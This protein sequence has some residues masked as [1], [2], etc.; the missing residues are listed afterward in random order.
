MNDVDE[1]KFE[2]ARDE[3]ESFYK[4]IGEVWCP[5]LQEKVIFNAKGI[6]H[7][8]FKAIRQARSHRDQYIRFRLI[9]LAPKIIQSSH[10]L[11]GISMRKGFEREK[12]HNRWEI[13]MRTATYFEFVAVVRDVRVRIIVKQVENGP[14]YFWSIIPFWK[15]DKITGKRLLHNGKPSE[16]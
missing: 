4:T 12:T 14:K 8:K 10:T 13:V 6:E 1:V 11:Q 2:K 16:D 7:I 9:S 3:A 15:M 5:Y